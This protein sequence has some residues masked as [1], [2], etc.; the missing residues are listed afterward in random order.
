MHSNDIKNIC[1]VAGAMAPWL[2]ALAAF[3]EDPDLVP[4]AHMVAH[5]HL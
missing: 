4:S 5:T 3:A 2:R 1:L